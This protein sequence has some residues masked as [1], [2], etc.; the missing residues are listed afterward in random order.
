MEIF[1]G[2][3]TSQYLKVIIF[4][5]V[6]FPILLVFNILSVNFRCINII[7]DF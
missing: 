7:E 1:I 2:S 6:Q 3:K 5:I 4:L